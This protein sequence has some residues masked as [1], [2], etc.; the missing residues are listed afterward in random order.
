MSSA[1]SGDNIKLARPLCHVLWKMVLSVLFS[2]TIPYM[3]KTLSTL[4]GEN[5]SLTRPLSHELCKV[6]L[7]VFS[8]ILSHT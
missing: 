7:S 6:V 3:E 4:F 5:I 2:Y 8:P 1:M